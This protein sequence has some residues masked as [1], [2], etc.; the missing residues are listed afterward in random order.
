MNY[1]QSPLK[2]RQ[3]TAESRCM[4]FRAVVGIYVFEFMLFEP[5]E[6]KGNMPPE[7]RGNKGSVPLPIE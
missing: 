2:M 6:P 7:E 5:P 3:F 1:D 4:L